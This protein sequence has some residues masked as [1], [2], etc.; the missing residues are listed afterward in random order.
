MSLDHASGYSSAHPLGWR[1]IRQIK[2]IRP[3][4]GAVC[5]LVRWCRPSRGI[6]PPL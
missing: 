3:G 5:I 6:Y 1:D 2:R 4:R